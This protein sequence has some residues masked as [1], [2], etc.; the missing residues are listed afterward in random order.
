MFR[1]HIIVTVLGDYLYLVGGRISEYSN[2]V[3]PG[4]NDWFAFASS[5]AVS[6]AHSWD[7]ATVETVPSVW[8]PSHFVDFSA[9]WADEEGDVLY[10]WGG[11]DTYGRRVPSDVQGRNEAPTLWRFTA[12]GGGS[13]KWEAAG[14]PPLSTISG[15]GD[16]VY[17][18][19]Q[20]GWA[21][22]GRKGLMAGGIAFAATDARLDEDEA[23]EPGMVVY[24]LDSHSWE[25]ESTATLNWPE[26]TLVNTA[27]VCLEKDDH[28]A[29]H[30][31][32]FVLG[33][34]KRSRRSFEEL[35]VRPFDNITFFDT[36][37]R[38]WHWQE[39]RGQVPRSRERF[40]AAGQRGHNGT[41]EM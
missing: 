21:T 18:A 12:D 41:Y 4:N 23:A 27:G 34:T 31:L 13:G 8:G 36:E 10:R 25:K 39:A 20:G 30:P 29:S 6:L 32:F 35:D 26:G 1:A 14:A 40:C 5:Y 7:N 17:A 16:D 22:C 9:L 33:G 24:D 3:R 28:L 37:S 15:S 2:G 38:T 19:A 11:R